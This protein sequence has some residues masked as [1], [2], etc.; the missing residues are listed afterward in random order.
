MEN[1][2]YHQFS[3]TPIK[4]RSFS[5]QNLTR[6]QAPDLVGC[7]IVQLPSSNFVL[8]ELCYLIVNESEGLLLPK[9]EEDE[10]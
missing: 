7:G 10:V 3:G 6:L 1:V 5:I 9:E 8:E 4:E 2:T